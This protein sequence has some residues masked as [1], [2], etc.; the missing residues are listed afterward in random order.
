M[1]VT[2]SEAARRLG[3]SRRTLYSWAQTGELPAGVVVRPP[4]GWP[5]IN[6]A[7]LLEW[8]EAGCPGKA[9]KVKA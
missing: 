2:F 7:K 1:L 5:R 3:Y 6:Y 8:V 4:S 9:R